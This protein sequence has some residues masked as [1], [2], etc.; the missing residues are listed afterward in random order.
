MSEQ[1]A[2]EKV[3]EKKPSPIGSLIFGLISA[4]LMGAV[5][6]GVVFVSPI[7][8]SECNVAES[9]EHVEP[10]KKT[11]SY[12]DIAFVNLEPLVITLGPTAESEF[13]KISVS[14]ETTKDKAKKI[15]HLK[16]MFRDVLNTY[17]RAVNEDDLA[18]P[19]AMTRLRAQLL[20]RLQLVA[21]TETVSNVLITEFVL[22]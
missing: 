9:S 15:E 18:N 2:P 3:Q 16:P 17:L 5:A 1:E 21:S 7:G 12:E 4:I 19:A 22:N 20:R 10:K 6:A 13:L 11:K 14:L 8:K